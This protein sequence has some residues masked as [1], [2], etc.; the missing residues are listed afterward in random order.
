MGQ[1]QSVRSESEVEECIGECV[2]EK[3]MSDDVFRPFTPPFAQLQS[4]AGRNKLIGVEREL[5]KENVDLKGIDE[6]LGE[7]EDKLDVVY[8]PVLK[9]YYE[10]KT[11]CYYQRD[12][13]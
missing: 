9:C 10:P 6:E 12:N 1:E 11:G 5:Q 7:Q 2:E 3:M 4:F 8:D 13:I